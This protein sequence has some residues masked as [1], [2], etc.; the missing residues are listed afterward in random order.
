V[1]PNPQT[2]KP[3]TPPTNAPSDP[4]KGKPGTTTTPQK[5]AADPNQKGDKNGNT[6]PAEKKGLRSK[7]QP[8]SI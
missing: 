6:T 4:S 8:I 7:V 3:A 5:P 1:N 2:N